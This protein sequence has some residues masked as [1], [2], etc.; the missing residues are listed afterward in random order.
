MKSDSHLFPRT[1][2]PICWL[3]SALWGCVDT[4]SLD[5]AACDQEHP[6][7]RTHLCRNQVCIPR[8]ECRS[9]LDCPGD[10]VCLPEERFCVSCYNNSHCE[11]GVC[12]QSSNICVTCMENSDCDQGVCLPQSNTCVECRVRTDCDTG[13][14]DVAAHICR[15][16]KGH[17][18][19][20]TGFCDFQ[21]GFCGER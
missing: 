4:R 15:G 5:G 19:C 9:D 6:C 11:Y 14:C 12:N 18:E 8:G 7:P 3:L 13:V 20:A 16:C 17:Y 2:I 10:S 21:T 1:L